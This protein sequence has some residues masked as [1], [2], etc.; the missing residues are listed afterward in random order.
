MEW[1]DYAYDCEKDETADQDDPAAGE[2]REERVDDHA[3]DKGI[4]QAD[5][6]IGA[7]AGHQPTQEAAE[8][9]TSNKDD[10]DQDRDASI[11]TLFYL[12]RYKAID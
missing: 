7:T 1:Q 4:H 10:D 12:V 5:E 9:D 8:C 2:A 6:D 11:E 3:E